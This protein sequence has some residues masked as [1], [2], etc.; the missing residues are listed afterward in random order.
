M[1]FSRWPRGGSTRRRRLKNKHLAG[2]QVV[3]YT[4]YMP[5][6]TGDK[7]GPCEIIAPIDAG[8][9]GEVW[10]E[11]DTRLNRVVA[12]KRLV[13]AASRMLARSLPFMGGQPRLRVLSSPP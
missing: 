12:L 3:L 8:D 11:R 13:N 7:L 10:K 9:M 6:S 4:C 5:L 1:F 2:S